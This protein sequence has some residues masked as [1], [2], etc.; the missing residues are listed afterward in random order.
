MLHYRLLI[1][2]TCGKKSAYTYYEHYRTVEKYYT[3]C[4]R[5]EHTF[6]YLN[7]SAG[8]PGNVI[9]SIVER[10]AAVALN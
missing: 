3:C 9:K 1:S 10:T 7:E 8:E 6:S 5:A 4:G 2:I